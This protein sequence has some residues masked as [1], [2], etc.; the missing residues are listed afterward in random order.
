M[1]TCTYPPSTYALDGEHEL[2]RR[3][4]DFRKTPICNHRGGMDGDDVTLYYPKFKKFTDDCNSDEAI[5]LTFA[6]KMCEE[7]SKYFERESHREEEFQKLMNEFLQDVLGEEKITKCPYKDETLGQTRVCKDDGAIQPCSCVILEVKNERHS[8]SDDAF[9]EVIAYYIQSFKANATHTGEHL[10]PVDQCPAPAFL[11]ELVGPHLFISG[12]VYGKYVFVDRLVD[13]VWLVPQNQKAMIRIA[14]IFKALKDAIRAIRSYYTALPLP[15]PQ[16]YPGQDRPDLIQIRH[17]I[18]T[19]H[20]VDNEETEISITYTKRLQA[21]MFEGI[22]PSLGNVQVMVH[23]VE[24]YNQDVHDQMHRKGLAPEI[25]KYAKAKGTRYK[26]IIMKHIDGATFF[27]DYLKTYPDEK[28]VIFE[29]CRKV[30]ATMH[31]EELCHGKFTHE[32]IL[33]QQ[34]QQDKKIFVVNFQFS[35]KFREK[36]HG[37]VITSEGDDA[38]LKQIKELLE[39]Q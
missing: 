9:S 38:S 27:A 19:L 31:Q 25:L 15:P 37:M 20:E 22:A 8:T 39:I 29:E 3:L 10:K 23:F 28:E 11:L 5:D 30:L 21:N 1:K 34:Q 7:M 14:Q 12:A 32:N 6:N 13:P 24:N 18:V 4:L 33:I 16:Y 35:G 17:P 2:R 26:A 36:R